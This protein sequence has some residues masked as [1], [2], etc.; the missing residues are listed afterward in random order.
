MVFV[1]LV[2]SKFDISSQ[3]VSSVCAPLQQ[4]SMLWTCLNATLAVEQVVKYQLYCI[5]K[6]YGKNIRPSVEKSLHET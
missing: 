4:V 6:T 1:V 5:D 3:A 2:V